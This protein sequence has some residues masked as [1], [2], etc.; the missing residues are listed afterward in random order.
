MMATE[1]VTQ[2]AERHGFTEW[3]TGGNCMALGREFGAFRILITD[4]DASLPDES[5]TWCVTVDSE[6]DTERLWEGD[7]A[8]TFPAALAEAIVMAARMEAESVQ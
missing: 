7:T 3:Q 8:E 2:V 5:G 6:S 4:G 1:T